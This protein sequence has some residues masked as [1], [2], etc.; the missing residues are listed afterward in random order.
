MTEWRTGAG[1]QLYYF[2]YFL[3]SV[4]YTIP[5]FLI[6]FFF[7]LFFNPPE[8]EGIPYLLSQEPIFGVSIVSIIIV[9]ARILDIF[10]DPLIA[11]K[12]DTLDHPEG[13]RLPFMK[14]A[15]LPAAFFASLLFLPP[16]G[17][18]ST[19]NTVWVTVFLAGCVMAFSAYVT[20]FLSNMSRL[21][22]TEHE[23]I[24]LS[25]FQGLGE[26]TG[27]IVAGQAPFLW[28]LLGET[29]YSPIESRQTAFVI[30]SVVAFFLMLIPLFTLKGTDRSPAEKEKI[31]FT[32]SIQLLLTNKNFLFFLIS[33]GLFITCVE[34]VQAGAYYFV[35]V[36][37]EMEATR[38]SGLIMIMVPSAIVAA[39]AANG[40]AKK[41]GKKNTIIFSFLLLSG[42]LGFTFFLGKIP[43]DREIQAY[44]LFILAGIPLGTMPLLAMT[45]VTEQ[46]NLS[47]R[48]SAQ[49]EAIYIAGKNFSYKSAITI[50][51]AL[52]ASLILSGK[53]RGD[54][55]GIRIAI[56]TALVFSIVALLFFSFFYKEP[57]KIKE[58]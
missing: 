22:Q 53:D 19:L 35:T 46:I 40:I 16:F 57:V 43:L 5:F 8:H 33:Y 32:E 38:V 41:I 11:H 26:S 6:A 34:M 47:A 31:H 4:G 23:R 36:L 12:S 20:P 56:I 14:K 24:N 18:N 1:M 9:A 44:T 13:R 49:L 28:T 52:F 45:I 48:N 15:I 2:T 50:G 3:G 30:L 27:I 7:V 55:L 42:L 51:A 58:S 39:L 29:G 10:V 37:L 25:T 54:D 21:C 17:D